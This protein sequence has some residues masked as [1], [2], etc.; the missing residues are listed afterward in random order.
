MSGN[1]RV[2]RVDLLEAGAC[3][4]WSFPLQREQGTSG[5]LTEVAPRSTRQAVWDSGGL[6]SDFLLSFT[7]YS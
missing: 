4:F 6:F 2:I 5:E 1:E 7:N 3:V